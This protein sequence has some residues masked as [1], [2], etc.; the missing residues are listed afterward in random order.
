VKKYEV[1]VNFFLLQEEISIVTN[2]EVFQKNFFSHKCSS[3]GQ[4]AELP[5]KRIVITQYG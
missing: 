5:L 3:K 1:E 4:G 2:S